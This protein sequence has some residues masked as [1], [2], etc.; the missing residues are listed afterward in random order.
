MRISA[1]FARRWSGASIEPL[2]LQNGFE[3]VDAERR[4]DFERIDKRFEQVE[5]R[6]E[7]VDKRFEGVERRFDSSDRRLEAVD[8]EIQ[9]LRTEM[10]ARFDAMQR[11]MIIGFASIVASVIATQI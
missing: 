2:E 9:K 11:T 7:A 5:Q 1:K 10:N 3:H 6:F 4:S 8:S